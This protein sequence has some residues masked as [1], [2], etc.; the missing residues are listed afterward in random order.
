MTLPPSATISSVT[1]AFEACEVVGDGLLLRPWTTADVPQL[2]VIAADPEI[3]RWNPITKPTVEQWVLLRADWSDGS[4]AS[5]AIVSPADPATVQG[6]VSLHHIDLAQANS[7]LGYWIAPSHRGAR[8]AARA[9][10]AAAHFGFE[11][12]ALRRVHL[13][14]AIENE[15]S[16]RVAVQAGFRYEGTHR[17]SYRFGDGQWHDEHSHARLND[18]SD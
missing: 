1:V 7:E 12:L 10:R 16:C 9:G 14:H 2:D 6:A 13:F 17:Q 5:W 18:D 3:V 15:A 8:L 11:A 4:H